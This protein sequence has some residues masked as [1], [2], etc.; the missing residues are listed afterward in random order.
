MPPRSSYVFLAAG[1][2][3]LAIAALLALPQ[4]PASA[5]VETPAPV[6]AET[7]AEL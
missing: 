4:G 6:V 7:V 1:P 5:E 3:M 2:L